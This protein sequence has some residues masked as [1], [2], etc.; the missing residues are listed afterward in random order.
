M[1]VPYEDVLL[2]SLAISLCDK[3][4]SDS[5]PHLCVMTEKPEGKR[6]GR[7]VL[8]VEDACQL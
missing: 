3:K 1:L 4:G 7:T 5:R 8:G 6:A 2:C